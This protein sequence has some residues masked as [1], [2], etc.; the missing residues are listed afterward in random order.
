MNLH[1][2]QSYEAMVELEEIAA[3]PHQI[4]TPR[5]GKPVISIVQDT[6]VG[7]YRLTR[8]GITFNK[9]EFM[10]LMIYNRRF[11]GIMPKPRE[12]NE[13]APKWTGQQVMSQLL[14]PINMSMGNGLYDKDKE[15]KDSENYVII[16]NGEMKQGVID[17]SVFSKASSGIIH[18]SYNDYGPQQT[19]DLIDGMQNMVES[20]LIQNGLSVGISDLIADERTRDEMQTR[21]QA[22]T[23]QVAEIILQVHLDLFDNKTGNTNQQEFENRVLTVLNQATNEAGGVGVKSLADN[24]RLMSMV[25]SGSKG[26]TFNVSQMMASVGQQNI[27]GKRIQY[28][29]TD[30]TLPHYKKYDDGAEA[31]GFIESS[32]I[33]GLTPQEFFFHAMSGRE[34]LIDTAVKSVTGDTPLV[35]LENGKTKRVTIGE[36]IDTQ[37]EANA[38]DVQHYEARN[39]EYLDVTKEMYI[40]TG[41]A[42]GNVT[43][44][45]IKAVTRHDPGTELYEVISEGGRKVIVTESQS[46]L[47]WDSIT[48]KFK[49][50]PSPDVKIGDALPVT[51]KLC[52]PPIMAGKIIVSDYLSKSQYIYGTDFIKATDA[53]NS[54]MIDREK[55]PAGWW[56]QNNGNTFT[57]PYDSKARLQRATV[58]SN[59]D[60]IA[61]GYVYPFSATRE[62]GIPDEF[63]LNMDNGVMLGLFLAEGNVDVKSG[64]IQITNNNSNIR[65]FVDNWFHNIGLSTKE[66]IRE[67]HIGGTSSDIR[68]YSTILAKFFDELVGHGAG[69]KKVPN[70][71]FAA[72][73]EFIIGLLNGYF[74]G[75]GTIGEN[76]I[77]AGSASSELITGISMLCNRINVFGKLSQVQLK[78]NN[79]GTQ[80]IQP[81]Y[82]IAIRAQWA[83]LFAKTVP[84]IDDVKQARLNVLAASERHRN[85]IEQNDMVLD[86]IIAINVMGVEKYPKVYDL[87]IPSTFNFILAN[88]LN[89][90]DTAE[91]GYIQRKLVKGMEDLVVH[92]DGTVRD[93]NMNIIQYQYGED[94]INAT[95]LE[96]VSYPI[97]SMTRQDVITKFGLEGVDFENEVLQEGIERESDADALKT[98]VAEVLED[99]KTLI[100]KVFRGT[101]NNNVVS[102]VN[103]GRLIETI[104]VRFSLKKDART[105]L[106]PIYV[107]QGIKKVYERTQTFSSLWAGLL[108]YYLAPHRL[109]VEERFTKKAFDTLCEILIV[110]N[111]QSWVVP[112]E[113]VGILA[114]QSIGE[115]STQMVLNTFHTAGAS[116]TSNVSG[117]LPRLK[118][119]LI[120]TASPAA[121]S[122]TIYLKDEFKALKEK[123]REVSQELE[124]T[125]LRDITR[126]CAI[127]YDPK[128]DSTVI[129]E[130]RSLIE[131]YKLFEASQNQKAANP[132]MLRLEFDREKMFNKNIS[133]YDVAF[134]L[135]DKFEDIRLIYSDYN[136]QK[137]IMRIRIPTQTSVDGIVDLKKFQ[138]KLLNG[139]IL[140]GSVG[141]KSVSFRKE[142]A[143]Q[144][145][146][147]EVDGV[148]K[149]DV[150]FVLDTDGSNFLE[151]MNHPAVNGNKLYSTNVHDLYDQLGMEAARA[152]LIIEFNKIFAEVGVGARHIGLMVDLMTRS[153]RLMSMDRYGIFTR[154]IGPLAKASFE[155]A[156]E[157]LLKASIFGEVDPVKGVSANIMVGQPLKG[158]TAFSQIML[159]ESAV[160]NLY[161]GLPPINE[162]EEEE[163]DLTALEEAEE[164][165]AMDECSAAKFQMT[166]ALPPAGA[167]Q[168]EEDVELNIME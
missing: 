76:S 119:L 164:G 40:P 166:V 116:R 133:M 26:S 126:S 98:Y 43:W 134:I 159:D 20:F 154:D 58:R 110:K 157:K 155:T 146:L 49:E 125:T 128:D 143:N 82:R 51:A 57:L 18:V 89:V 151:V 52:V 61:E 3:V 4:I 45:Q 24:N 162:Y 99:R 132:W 72:P 156:A 109:I 31:R 129:E 111:W 88:G 150:E 160:V 168:D 9:R 102:P 8:S 115:P 106:T 85:F 60:S 35:I 13:Q 71:A 121:S 15:G 97:G 5:H 104:K 34:G 68:G 32:F 137:L 50:T 2:P 46:L 25:R 148:Y 66:T 90:R 140:R 131:F 69:N 28:G 22:K 84:L 6:L 163:A 91:T 92:H 108:R 139:V 12:G 167:I 122:L 1:C 130:D 59:M 117:G 120:V 152:G 136:A 144:A 41:D 19:V 105:D 138:N 93:A 153:G 65:K 62:V 96:Y 135:R 37:L 29:F 10:N 114:A 63:E 17:S 79:L 21:I 11:M 42:D 165:Y 101:M 83:T 16:E 48:N 107:L 53:M 64:Y 81:T 124:L 158:G 77:E 73:D 74:S 94:G 123:A 14:P 100:E 161:K 70:E 149:S 80:V 112:G 118:E 147:K 55:I 56:E 39:M 38:S 75:D 127:Y 33:R 27:E 44:G 78:S 30:R 23:K 47:I 86:R 95:K 54:A 141:L 87:T 67:N 103:I 145:F 36:W 7:A 113:L 142:K